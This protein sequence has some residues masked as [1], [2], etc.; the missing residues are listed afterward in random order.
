MIREPE[1]AYNTENKRIPRRGRKR[2]YSGSYSTGTYDG[3]AQM[4]RGKRE[5]EEELI[6]DVVIDDFFRTKSY[7]IEVLEGFRKDMTNLHSE[8]ALYIYCIFQ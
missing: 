7:W 3:K 4:T 5:A 6:H 1:L 2:Q 8:V